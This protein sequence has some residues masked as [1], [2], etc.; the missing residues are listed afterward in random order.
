[1]LLGSDLRG[2]DSQSCS[3]PNRT[4]Y[5]PDIW[6]DN[7]NREFY[8][9]GTISYPNRQYIQDYVDRAMHAEAYNEYNTC[10]GGV[11]LAA[12][13]H[14][15]MVAVLA[16]TACEVGI[17]NHFRFLISSFKG[18]HVY[19]N[20]VSVLSRP[21]HRYLTKL[22]M[23]GKIKILSQERVSNKIFKFYFFQLG[24]PRL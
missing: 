20:V 8:G 10:P 11:A 1:M 17:K 19:F 4:I 3:I 2:S 18:I 7:N 14:Y 12:L 24:V 23:F 22:S 15:F 16:W 9:Y 13:A 5:E 6:P 21:R